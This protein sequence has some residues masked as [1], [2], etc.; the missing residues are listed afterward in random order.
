MNEEKKIDKLSWL[1][2]ISIEIIYWNLKPVSSKANK[3]SR[4]LVFFDRI[5]LDLAE[6]VNKI[7]I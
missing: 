7:T 4:R 6:K 3:V 2:S 1:V 5:Q